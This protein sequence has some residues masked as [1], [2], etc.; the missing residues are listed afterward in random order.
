MQYSSAIKDFKQAIQSQST[1]IQAQYALAISYYHSGNITKA[2]SHFQKTATLAR[3][4]QDFS[5]LSQVYLRLAKLTLKNFRIQD[6]HSLLEEAIA[7]DPKNM[8]A[9]V[10]K[11]QMEQLQKEYSRVKVSA[12]VL[13]EQLFNKDNEIVWYGMVDID[14]KP[15]DKKIKKIIKNAMDISDAKWLLQILQRLQLCHYP[16]NQD[17][18]L[19]WFLENSP[20]LLIQNHITIQQDTLSHA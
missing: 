13:F 8:D 14:L 6:A 7:C 5:L 11:I 10:L 18:I 16:E 4:D 12:H 9:Q 3:Q 15:F 1:H 2:Q 17:K 20:S 19:V